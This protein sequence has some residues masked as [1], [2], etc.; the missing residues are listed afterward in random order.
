MELMAKYDYC[1]TFC[2]KL[3]SWFS[4]H[5]GLFCG[6]HQSQVAMDLRLEKSLQ[7]L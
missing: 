1:F 3:F 5:F 7:S 6:I 2:V 4:F